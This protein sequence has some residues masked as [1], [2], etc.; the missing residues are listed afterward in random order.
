MHPRRQ[1]P[2]TVVAVLARLTAATALLAAAGAFLGLIPAVATA[3]PAVTN[4]NDSGPGSLRAAV[5]GAGPEETVVVPPGTYTLTS[6]ELVI[7]KSLILAGSGADTT[8]IRAG[9]N[10]RVIDVDASGPPGVTLSDLTVTGGR[11]LASPLGGGIL[12]SA[13]Q[14]TL[15]GVHV[16]DNV[17]EG[18]VTEGAG[19]AVRTPGAALTVR[20][21]VI[22]GNEAK[23]TA[24][25]EGGG[26]YSRESGAVTVERSTFTA[27]R[28]ESGVI[29]EGGGIGIRGSGPV[30]I[31]AS[32]VAGNVAGGTGTIVVGGGLY[33]NEMKEARLAELTVSGNQ[34]A[35]NSVGSGGGLYVGVSSGGKFSI[36][37]STLVGNS[38]PTGGNL[39]GGPDVSIG[40][41]VVSGGSGD[42]GQENCSVAVTSLG[43]NLESADQCGFHSPGDKVG[44]DPQLGPLQG[45][46]GPTA[47]MLPAPTGP[48]VDQGASF[49]LATDQRGLPRPVEYPGVPNSTAPGADGS[50]IG[51]VELQPPPPVGGRPA[52]PSSAVVPLTLR[53]GKLTKNRKRGTATLQVS[54]SAPATGTLRLSGKG[55][56]RRIRRLSGA[57]TATLGVA[58]NRKTRRLLRRDGGRKF[59][60]TVS[61]APS[62][63]GPAL[64]A[65]RKVAL[66]RKPGRPGRGTHHG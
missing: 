45:N 42:P 11:V 65:G 49:G 62:V 9:G 31:L 24:I 48:L 16:V 4:A 58:G 51:A 43:F 54:F 12:S 28:A 23:A 17:V 47:T 27:N 39:A 8:I 61:F 46:G 34:A 41:S 60:L 36:L 13:S 50:D 14:L 30:T 66:A 21:S 18:P 19:V 64:T 15:D 1:L 59:R 32:T 5:E 40:D 3:A 10:F 55:L 57:T 20:D 33:L 22:A 29:V 7:A 37:A 25:S 63:G 35:G 53:L 6:G 56:E 2:P 44:L 52:P 26:L 38:A